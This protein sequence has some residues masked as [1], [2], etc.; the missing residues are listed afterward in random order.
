[1]S[2]KHPTRILNFYGQTQYHPTYFP[3]RLF[4]S[5]EYTP[6]IDVIDPLTGT[7]LKTITGLPSGAKVLKTYFKY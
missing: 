4:V 2:N 6:T 1:M 7:K 3:D 5:F